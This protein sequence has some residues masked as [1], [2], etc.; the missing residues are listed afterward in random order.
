MTFGVAVAVQ[1]IHGMSGN[2]CLTHDN[3]R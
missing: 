3:L 1:A 2:D